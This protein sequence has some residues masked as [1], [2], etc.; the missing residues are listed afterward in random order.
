VRFCVD[1]WHW[2]RCQSLSSVRYVE[3]VLLSFNFVVCALSCPSRRLL[4]IYIFVRIAF[5]VL[6]LRVRRVGRSVVF[7]RLN[8][9]N[10]AAIQND[11]Y[12]GQHSKQS[13]CG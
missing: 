4:Y 6:S 1:S 8:F 9:P 3:C 5:C 12:E 13:N 11:S 10:S 2:Q 7:H